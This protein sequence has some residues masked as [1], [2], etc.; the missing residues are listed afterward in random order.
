VF[1]NKMDTSGPSTPSV[2]AKFNF[3]PESSCSILVL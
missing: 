2:K 3:Q 1:D